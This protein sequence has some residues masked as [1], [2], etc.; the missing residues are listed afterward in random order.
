MT[1]RHDDAAPARRCDG[2]E[3]VLIPERLLRPSRAEPRRGAGSRTMAAT[4]PEAEA[5]RAALPSGRGEFS[6]PWRMSVATDP[7]GRMHPIPNGIRY[8]SEPRAGRQRRGAAAA[9]A[10]A[11]G[12]ATGSEPAR[13]ATDWR[14]ASPALR[15]GSRRRAPGS[16]PAASVVR[17]QSEAHV[18]RLPAGFRSSCVDRRRSRSNRRPAPAAAL[19]AGAARRPRRQRRR[20]RARSTSA[21]A[22]CPIRP[23]RARSASPI[24]LAS[25]NAK[26]YSQQH[27]KL[28]RHRETS[29]R[30]D[31]SDAH[32]RPVR[33]G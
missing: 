6:I 16:S 13:R 11:C 12:C 24:P 3:C 21:G 22:S 27:R 4:G 5:V 31:R 29:G 20:T 33:A 8:A 2:A 15:R 19:R 9:N 14:L 25:T 18:D 17:L 32:Q 28:H 7:G 1:G 30:G 23:S 26:S 10:A